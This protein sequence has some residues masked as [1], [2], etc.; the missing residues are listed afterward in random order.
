[1]LPHEK[2]ELAV[3]ATCFEVRFLRDGGRHQRCKCQ[4]RL[5]RG[6][7]GDT[8]CP[9]GLTLCKVCA[10]SLVGGFSRFSWLACESCKAANKKFHFKMGFKLPLGRHSIMNGVSIPANVP[11]AEVEAGI[12]NMM[13]LVKSWEDLNTWCALKTRILFESVPEWAEMKLIPIDLWEKKFESSLEGSLNSFAQFYGVKDAKELRKRLK[14]DR[15]H[16]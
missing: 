6:E 7:L 13:T 11:K 5:S 4:G 9:N 2:K 16:G 1:M 8:D 10:R 12:S 14:E 15:I 3:C